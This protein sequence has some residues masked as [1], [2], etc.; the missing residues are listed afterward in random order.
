MSISVSRIDDARR[1]IESGDKPWHVLL[2]HRS[3]KVELFAPRG[4]DQQSSH[5]QDEIY[6]V[7]TG[8]ATLKHETREFPCRAGD[9]I[10]VRATTNHQF[11]NMSDDF[12]TWVIFYGPEGGEFDWSA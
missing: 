11:T 8:S 4:T 3:M 12:E 5:K 9:V 10:F 7:Q 6:I 2:R 1:A